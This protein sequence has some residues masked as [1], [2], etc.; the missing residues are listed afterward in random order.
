MLGGSGWGGRERGRFRARGEAGRWLRE[1]RRWRVLRVGCAAVGIG[2]RGRVVG[3]GLG[4]P[5]ASEDHLPG[6]ARSGACAG[7]GGGLGSATG[8]ARSNWIAVAANGG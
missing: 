2:G 7:L 8:R 3:H 6:V 1:S 5:H 4:G